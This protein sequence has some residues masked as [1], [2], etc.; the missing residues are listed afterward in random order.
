MFL[1][2]PSFNIVKYRRLLRRENPPEKVEVSG[3]GILQHRWVYSEAYNFSLSSHTMGTWGENEAA[4]GKAS[5]T[6]T[7]PK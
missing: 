7:E 3:R 4:E 2:S 1:G 6:H 5:H